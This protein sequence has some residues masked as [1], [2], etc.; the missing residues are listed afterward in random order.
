MANTSDTT[1]LKIFITQLDT[2]ISSAISIVINKKDRNI[3]SANKDTE[4]ISHT[5][6]GCAENLL[7]ITAITIPKTI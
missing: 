5:F 4:S 7:P 3:K 6:K 2:L 1:I